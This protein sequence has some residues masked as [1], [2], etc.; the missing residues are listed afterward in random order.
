MSL[1]ML[2]EKKK[3]EPVDPLGGGN[4]FHAMEKRWRSGTS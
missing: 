4:F 1:L 2:E 3:E